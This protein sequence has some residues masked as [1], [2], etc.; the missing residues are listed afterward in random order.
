MINRLVG[1]A[2]ETI[3]GSPLARLAPGLNCDQSRTVIAELEKLDSEAVTWNE[4][5]QNENK[6]RRQRGVSFLNPMNWIGI[7]LARPAIKRGRRKTR[8]D[9]RPFA[10]LNSLSSPCAVTGP[11]TAT[12]RPGWS[13]LFRVISSACRWIRSMAGP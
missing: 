1:V 11:S 5:L 7:W 10:P 2:C 13:N 12:A 8:P 9:R 3:G 6:F 4:I